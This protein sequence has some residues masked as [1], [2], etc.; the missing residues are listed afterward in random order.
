MLQLVT[1]RVRKNDFKKKTT[2]SY[3]VIYFNIVE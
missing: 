2:L 1:E 3:S